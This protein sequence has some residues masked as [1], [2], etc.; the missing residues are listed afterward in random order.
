MHSKKL[1]LLYLST[2]K[3]ADIQ[4]LKMSQTIKMVREMCTNKYNC[5]ATCMHVLM[6]TYVAI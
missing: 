1:L 3:R 6:Y 5:I 4:F 2:G